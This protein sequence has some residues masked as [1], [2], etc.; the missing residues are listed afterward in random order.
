[1]KKRII[2]TILT[3]GLAASVLGACEGSGQAE[4]TKKAEGTSPEKVEN[5]ADGEKTELLL[6]M[7]PFGTED[8]LDKETW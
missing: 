2:S 4:G 7:P 5:K 3:L 1:M 6:W 8:T